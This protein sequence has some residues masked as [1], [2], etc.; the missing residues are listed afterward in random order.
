MVRFAPM[1]KLAGLLVIVLTSACV[2][3]STV[4]VDAG[5]E[6]GTLGGPCFSN[7]TCDTGLVCVLV[8]S[9]GICEV[10]DAS[11]DTTVDA[12]K[13]APNEASDAGS[14]ACVSAAPGTTPCTPA[15]D[16]D[17][18][19]KCCVSSATCQNTTCPNSLLAGNCEGSGDCINGY[20]CLAVNVDMT[21]CPYAVNN[22]GTAASCNTAC[23]SGSYALCATNGECPTSST[24]KSVTSAGINTPLGLCF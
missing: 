14:D 3:D 19:I 11:A 20:C 2:S 15:C 16:Y 23:P 5:P 7:S 1:S 22:P 18:G 24:C 13:D 17:A 8:G 12:P 6:A 21:V 9:S 10:P 4:I